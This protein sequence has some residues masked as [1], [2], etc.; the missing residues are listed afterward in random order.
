MKNVLNVCG[1]GEVNHQWKE[2]IKISSF[3]NQLFQHPQFIT[4][5]AS[6]YLMREKCLIFVKFI[7]T[8]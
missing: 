5:L 1:V 7:Q 3:L 4:G 6:I 8:C 2:E